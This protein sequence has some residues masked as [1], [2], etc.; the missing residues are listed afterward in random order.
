[1]LHAFIY[2]ALKNVWPLQV[3]QYTC[4]FVC[5]GVSVF[6]SDGESDCVFCPHHE[7][8][9]V[10]VTEVRVKDNEVRVKSIEA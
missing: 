3:Q 4:G 9:L 2:R 8:R 10:S 6:V 5:L 7:K 1:M